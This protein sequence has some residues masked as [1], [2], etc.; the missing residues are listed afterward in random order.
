MGIS[1]G[2]SISVH[3]FVKVFLRRWHN[4]RAIFVR[5]NVHF[6]NKV[7]SLP[8]RETFTPFLY[9]LLLSSHNLPSPWT[10]NE[11]ELTCARKP[12]T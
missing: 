4:P 7:P 2:F 12:I 11:P 6:N 9:V 1:R 8:H 10:L 3:I 5:K